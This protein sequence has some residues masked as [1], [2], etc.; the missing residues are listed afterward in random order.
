M[1]TDPFYRDSIAFSKHRAI[2][3]SKYK[4]IYIPT[5]D[6]VEYELFDRMNDPLNKI[7]LYPSQSIEPFRN[8]LYS[9]SKKWENSKVISEYILPPP[10]E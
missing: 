10:L 5:H 3:N 7:N 1:I 4:F 6:G 9:I 8:E 2:I